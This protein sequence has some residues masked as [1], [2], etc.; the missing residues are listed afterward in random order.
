MKHKFNALSCELDGIKFSSKKERAY[1][2]HLKW[3]K[4]EGKILFFLMQVPFSLPGNIKYRLDFMEFW[5]PVGVEP[6][7]IVFTEVKGFKTPIGQLKIAQCEEI[8]GIK[9]NVI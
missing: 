5:A 7:E 1:Y 3:L 8:Y 6:G 2:N 9:I 4:Q